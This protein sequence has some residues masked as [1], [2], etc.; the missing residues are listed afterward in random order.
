MTGPRR[1]G[2]RRSGVKYRAPGVL[3]AVF[4]TLFAATVLTIVVYFALHA[5]APQRL[6]PDQ[7]PGVP[8]A[9]NVKEKV[10]IVQF[11]FGVGRMEARAD[12]NVEVDDKTGRLE[13]SVAITRSMA[14]T[15]Q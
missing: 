8:D 1:A 7:K 15:F 5:R 12:R 3:R 11:N 2:G 9:S 10:S 14:R 6:E 4:G 13:G